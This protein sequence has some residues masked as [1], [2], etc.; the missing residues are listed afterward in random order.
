MDHQQRNGC[1]VTISPC[2][3]PGCKDID[4][5][6]TLTDTQFC[7]RCAG[8]FRRLLDDIQDAYI[9]LKSE[10][11]KPL[12]TVIAARAVT[13]KG[14]G[15]PREWASNLAQDLTR[16]C[17]RYLAAFTHHLWG[18]KIT[19]AF[20]QPI[21]DVLRHDEA[22]LMN[23]CTQA[24]RQSFE[25]LIEW[26]Q[27]PDMAEELT[28]LHNRFRYGTGKTRMARR[29]IAPCPKCDVRALTMTDGSDT[30]ECASCWHR[31]TSTDAT[32]NTSAQLARQQR[33]NFDTIDRLLA[34]YDAIAE[35]QAQAQG[36]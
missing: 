29:L 34:D 18:H 33:F 1:T 3:Y 16:V 14:F 11:P 13:A 19:H 36:Q 15:H 7:E 21:S 5:N 12:V 26:D 30:V 23:L 35:T 9:L 24:V 4:G 8:R 25:M 27:C 10:L 22:K 2:R 31:F 32:Q 17:A 6:P 28:I 20:G